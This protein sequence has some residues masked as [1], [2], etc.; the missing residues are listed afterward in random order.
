MTKRIIIQ[1]PFGEVTEAARK[2]AALNMKED[3]DLFISILNDLTLLMGGDSAK[4]MAELKRRYPEA[5]EDYVEE[6]TPNDDA[7]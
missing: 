1:S 3:P 5:L 7:A 6:P 4:G 2:R